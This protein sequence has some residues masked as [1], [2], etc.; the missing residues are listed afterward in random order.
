AEC[1]GEPR[2]EPLGTN[3]DQVPVG[4]PAS[5]LPVVEVPSQVLRHGRH[6]VRR[7]TAADRL[8]AVH[9]GGDGLAGGD[10]GGVAGA[11]GAPGA[12][13]P[14]EQAGTAPAVPARGAGDPLDGIGPAGARAARL[15]DVDLVTAAV[16]H[17]LDPPGVTDH[18]VV[19]EVV[20]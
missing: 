13:D 7:A 3:A 8:R 12:R 15:P 18:R 6:V 1:G 11:A 2:G 5:R 4:L 17:V 16:A 20:R 10:G 19:A 14:G 9:P